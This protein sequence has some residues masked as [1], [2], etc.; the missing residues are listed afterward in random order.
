MKMRLTQNTDRSLRQSFNQPSA[1]GLCPCFVSYRTSSYVVSNHV[2]ISH[3][4]ACD[5][6]RHISDG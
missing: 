5:T 3:T 1:L 4:D 6:V 2:A